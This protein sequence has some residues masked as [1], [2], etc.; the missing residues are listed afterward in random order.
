VDP[1]GA[2]D[3]TSTRP[4]LL[5]KPQNGFPQAPTGRFVDERRNKQRKM[6][7][8]AIEGGSEHYLPSSLRSDE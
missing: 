5:G 8:L 3:A 4:P 2:A 6:T 1:A 7:P